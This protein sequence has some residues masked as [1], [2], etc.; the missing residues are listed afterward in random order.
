MHTHYTNHESHCYVGICPACKD[1]V[2]WDDLDG[3]V[4]TC[5]ADLSETNPYREPAHP[6]ITDELRESSGVFSNCGDDFG[7]PCY[8][9]MPLHSECYE[10][11]NY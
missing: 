3:P 1:R 6:D 5:P 9:A 2:L 8:D 7:F 11:G 10:K 4:W